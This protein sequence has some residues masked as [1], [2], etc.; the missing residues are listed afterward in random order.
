MVYHTCPGSG[1]RGR[2]H[3]AQ[4]TTMA[5]KSKTPAATTKKTPKAPTPKKAAPAAATPPKAT[6]TKK[7]SALAAAALVLEEA[8][9]PTGVREMVEAM[10]AKGYWTSPAGATP[11]ATLAAAIAREIAAKGAA[12]RFRKTGKGRFAA[13]TATTATTTATPEPTPQAPRKGKKKASPVAAAAADGT[14]GP[15]SLRELIRF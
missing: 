8:L 12:S 4:E 7:L 14:A 15:E 5:S 2:V 3:T 13:A 11:H 6:T 10:A 1:R 9:V